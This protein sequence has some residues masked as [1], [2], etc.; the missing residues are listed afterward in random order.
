MMSKADAVSCGQGGRLGSPLA[1]AG[2]GLGGSLGC[3]VVLFCFSLWF[4]AGVEKILST[5]ACLARLPL[6]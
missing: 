4:L 5:I 2:K 6:S 3:R 1:S